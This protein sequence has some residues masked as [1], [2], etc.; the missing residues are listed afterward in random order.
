MRI[1]YLLLIISFV[2][3]INGDWFDDL[4]DNLHAKLVAGAD[5]IK[6]KAAPAL[7]EKFNDAKAKLQDPETHHAF[8]QWIQ[9]KAIPAV[10]EKFDAA[11]DFW[12]TEV[13]P[14]L[15]Q[16]VSAYEAAKNKADSVDEH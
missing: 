3:N 12:K 2:S 6:E 4:V 1:I 8:R 10:K 14:E 9:E 5:Y 15:K 11:A 16:I 7:R 13:M